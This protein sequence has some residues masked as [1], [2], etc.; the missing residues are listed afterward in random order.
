VIFYNFGAKFKINT[1]NICGDIVDL[2]DIREHR[3][4]MFSQ[5][6]Y[7]LLIS[8]SANISVTNFN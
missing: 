1:T 8:S 2:L 7:I 5:T 3:F 4:A 6:S